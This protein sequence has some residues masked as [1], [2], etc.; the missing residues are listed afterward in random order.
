MAK[1]AW[2]LC[3]TGGRGCVWATLQARQELGRAA[4]QGQVCTHWGS[5]SG[6]PQDTH[7]LRRLR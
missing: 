3:P 7:L 1:G 6:Q 4:R 5:I 2:G